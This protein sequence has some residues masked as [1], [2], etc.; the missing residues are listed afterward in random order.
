MTGDALGDFAGSGDAVGDVVADG[1]LDAVGDDSVVA[2][3][4]GDAELAVAA[5][6]GIWADATAPALATVKKF[7][8]S[9]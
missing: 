7:V 5:E 3:A 6:P 8:A 2:A 1:E 4:A 9:S